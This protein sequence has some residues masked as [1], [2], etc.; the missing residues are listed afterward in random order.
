MD[1][2]PSIEALKESFGQLP[3]IGPKS[4]E[5][6][7][8]AVLGMERNRVEEFSKRLLDV[9][10]N[11]AP[12]PVCGL[13]AEGGACPVC[14]DDSRD[15]STIM[16]VSSYK[17]ALAIEKS[18]CYK[19]LYH[20]LNGALSPSK[21]VYPE[22]LNIAPLLARLRDGTVKEVVVATNPNLEGETTALYLSKKIGEA[23]RVKVTRLA[24]GLS[25]GSSLEY[26]D[27]ITLEKAIEGRKGL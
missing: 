24:Y 19:G 23:S 21:G 13:Y 6:M 16:V 8:Y 1:L 10:N 17:D 3:G 25:M 20:C 4:A 26:S 18:D 9:K 15:K 5:R 12:C 11:I 27:A 7:A 2:L 22:D 14:S